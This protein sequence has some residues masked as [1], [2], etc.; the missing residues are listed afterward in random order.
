MAAG[1]PIK[2]LRCDVSL[3]IKNLGKVRCPGEH[4]NGCP[5]VKSN[6]LLT[7]SAAGLISALTKVAETILY[8]DLCS[9]YFYVYLVGL[10]NVKHSPFQNLK[11]ILK[12]HRE[13][14]STEL[15]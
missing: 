8:T 14:E 12:Y 2:W 15:S 13:F 4:P 11:V 7:K 10:E 5:L 1:L 3:K 9:I 6:S